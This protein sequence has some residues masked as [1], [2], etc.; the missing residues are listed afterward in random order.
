MAGQSGE[1]V[2]DWFGLVE[3]GAQVES[4]WRREWKKTGEAG[5]G[6]EEGVGLT[7]EGK[8]LPGGDQ[9][10]RSR[11][12]RGNDK[13]RQILVAAYRSGPRDGRVCG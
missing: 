10:G 7:G 1:H 13:L 3:F 4:S 6:A 5:A 11:P 12:W 2:G 8:N 9:R